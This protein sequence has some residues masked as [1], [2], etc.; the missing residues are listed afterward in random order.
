M[1]AVPNLASSTD[2]TFPVLAGRGVGQRAESSVQ[3][4]SREQQG[5]AAPFSVHLE[6]RLGRD[7]A[8]SEESHALVG[9]ALEEAAPSPT[10]ESAGFAESGQE[11]Q[12]TPIG[13]PTNAPSETDPGDDSAE[14]V[15]VAPLPAPAPIGTVGAAGESGVEPSSVQATS[16]V[17]PATLEAGSTSPIEPGRERRDSLRS[18][19]PG[20]LPAVDGVQ[21]RQDA[22]PIRGERVSNG[23]G[24][25]GTGRFESPVMNPDGQVSKSPGGSADVVSLVRENAAAASSTPA[26]GTDGAGSGTTSRAVAAE[27]RNETAGGVDS[28]RSGRFEVRGM[29]PVKEDVPANTQRQATA[30]SAVRETGRGPSLASLLDRFAGPT[31]GRPGPA[32]DP[33][34]ARAEQ[35]QQSIALEQAARSFGGRV[36]GAS[37]GMTPIT[38]DGRQGVLA[39]VTARDGASLETGARTGKI[40]NRALGVL[41]SQRGGTMMMRLDPPSLGELAVRMTVV[42]GSVRA[43]LNAGTDAAKLLLEQN[44]EMLKTSLE[45]RGLKVDRLHVSGPG[46]S[47]EPAG[48]RSESQQHSQSNGSGGSGDDGADE[49]KRDA[50]GRESR[51]RG[52]E[53]RGGTD[54]EKDSRRTFREAFE[55]D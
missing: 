49:G 25:A 53:R 39:E 8:A 4:L 40:A 10:D 29:T 47:G 41:A 21:L 50:A 52:G 32:V 43:D 19:V 54:Q 13:D 5:D 42:D 55:Q 23:R 31:E 38:A 9:R 6:D 48:V 33:A 45:S 27:L 46:A 44:I 18:G 22:A 36:G 1:A 7:G 35:V 34:M 16:G 26:T 12:E 14:S 11:T 37:T 2:P 51:G 30:E 15:P 17:V 20:T 24:A 28:R 3:T